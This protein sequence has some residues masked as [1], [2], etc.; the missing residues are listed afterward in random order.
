MAQ[1]R[2]LADAVLNAVASELKK[3][4]DKGFHHSDLNAGNILIRERIISRE[5]VQQDLTSD[6]E[7]EAIEHTKHFD[8]IFIDLDSMKKSKKVSPATRRRNIFRLFRS[9]KKYTAREKYTIKDDLYFLKSYRGD[10]ER[11][12]IRF[13]K[14]LPLH[15]LLLIFHRPYWMLTRKK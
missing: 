1:K 14:F 10:D 12:S 4:H 11:M 2:E 13:E 7:S 8:I 15:R 9:L 3:L 5:S 6:E